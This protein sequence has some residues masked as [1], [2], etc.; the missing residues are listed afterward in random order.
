MTAPDAF[1]VPIIRSR[2]TDSSVTIGLD[3][4]LNPDHLALLAADEWGLFSEHNLAVTIASPVGPADAMQ[5]LID[6]SC[7]LAVVEAVRLF[8]PAAAEVEALGCILR[9]KVAV[10][11]REER[12][13]AFRDGDLLRIASPASEPLFECACRRI[14]QGWA[15]GQ[16]IAVAANTIFVESVG[17]TPTDALLAGYDGAWVAVSA[18]DETAAQQRGLAVRLITAE[19]GGLPEV[20]G[21]EVVARG[22]R[23]QEQH[24]QHE[25]LLCAIDAAAAR[26]KAD[27]AMAV[28]LWRRLHSGSGRDAQELVHL[29]VAGMCSPVDR[30]PGRWHVLRSLV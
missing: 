11:M 24:G 22:Q 6:G 12:L 13:P 15:A 2:P 28:S 19:A 7:D 29:A 21:L 16:G 1:T 25:A 30:D 9:R 20:S 17:M 4:P 5:D 26:L 14:L 23:S 8:E 10:L 18:G 27:P 3:R